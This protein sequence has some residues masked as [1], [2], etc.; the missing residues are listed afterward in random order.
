MTAA[1][2]LKERQARRL[3]ELRVGISTRLPASLMARVD[4]ATVLLE[5]DGVQPTRTD[6]LELLIGYGLERLE[7]EHAAPV[8]PAKSRAAKR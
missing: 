7:G 4:M 5:A 8:T 6:V 2:L 3:R 1:Q